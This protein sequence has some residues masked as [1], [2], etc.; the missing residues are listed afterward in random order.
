[1]TNSSEY[2]PKIRSKTA[3]GHSA[4]TASQIRDLEKQNADEQYGIVLSSGSQTEDDI[5]EFTLKTERG[6]TPC[7]IPY[8]R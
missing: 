1:M 7:S 6:S 8:D 3:P 4:N 5:D 2:F